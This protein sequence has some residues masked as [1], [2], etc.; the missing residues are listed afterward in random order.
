MQ[1]A[2]ETIEG[3]L[4]PVNIG[5]VF[6]FAKQILQYATTDVEAIFPIKYLM[7]NDKLFL[8]GTGYNGYKTRVQMDIIPC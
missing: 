7:F 5:I 8:T 2:Y 6:C 4:E 3:C 1:I